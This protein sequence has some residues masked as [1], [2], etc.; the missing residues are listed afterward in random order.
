M[1]CET[2]A[3]KAELE[4]LRRQIANLS[5]I[6][7]E[8][9]IRKAVDRSKAA[10]QPEINRKLDGAE[11]PAIVEDSVDLANSRYGLA[12][13]PVALPVLARLIPYIGEIIKWLLALAALTASV[14]SL[15]NQ[16]GGFFDRLSRAEGRI[17][18]AESDIK[19][20]EK[21]DQALSTLR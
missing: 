7:E 11:R 21:Q 5:K 10:L 9:I 13:V 19:D 17:S 16:V 1:T 2:L 4:A 20:L 14:L 15:Q 3:T 6:D 12:M 18:A 8:S